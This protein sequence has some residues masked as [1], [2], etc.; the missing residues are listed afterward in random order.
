M[1]PDA[2]TGASG[3]LTL[4]IA[5][6]TRPTTGTSCSTRPGARRTVSVLS[7]AT[8][9][10]FLA[11]CPVFLVARPTFLAAFLVSLPRLIRSL[12]PAPAP[13]A[14]RDGRDR[15]PGRLLNVEL[16][17]S[18][19]GRTASRD[20]TWDLSEEAHSM[21]RLGGGDDVITLP[22]PDTGAAGTGVAPM[23]KPSRSASRKVGRVLA[24]LRRHVSNSLSRSPISDS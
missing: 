6:A 7:S 16:P 13:R 23:L 12:P 10:A 3:S 15:L 18:R 11:A 9:P 21:Q 14:D 22:P 24:P 19:G 17:R 1:D 20:D 4:G 8:V 2:A 5:P